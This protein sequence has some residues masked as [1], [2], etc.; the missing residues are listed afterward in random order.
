MSKSKSMIQAEQFV[1]A[2]KSAGWEISRVGGSIVTIS[3]RIEPNNNKEFCAA[4]MEYYGLLSLAPG[5]GGSIWG[6]DGGGIGA[7]S[8]MK[9]G[10]FVVNKSGVQSRFINALKKII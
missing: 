8:A 6:T 4:D 2:V 1:D 10:M 9:H 3:K 7:L 5:K